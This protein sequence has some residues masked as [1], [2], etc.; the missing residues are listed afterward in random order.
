MNPLQNEFSQYNSYIEVVSAVAAFA[1]KAL[2]VTQN[3]YQTNL[4]SFRGP[5]SYSEQS[6]SQT[7]CIQLHFNR[8]LSVAQWPIDFVITN[9]SSSA[10][11]DDDWF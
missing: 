3:P 1:V 5:K 9:I 7:N 2:A 11:T 4:F 10:F 8:Q 6:Q